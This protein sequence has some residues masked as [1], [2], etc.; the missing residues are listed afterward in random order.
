MNLEK[1]IFGF[2]IVLALT[3]NLGFVVG[4]IDNPL[5]HNVY[6]LSA[7]ILINLFAT[8]LKLGDRSHIGAVLLATSLV[9]NL[10]LIAAAL[11]W[12]VSSHIMSAG[13]TPGTMASI[14][15]LASGA[16]AANVISVII[17]VMDTMRV[18]R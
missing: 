8:G 15:S 9:A 17:L 3:V 4:D 6:E 7:A 10:Q 18:R 11:V 12:T 5:H 13:V 16:L 14:V 2:F 1:V